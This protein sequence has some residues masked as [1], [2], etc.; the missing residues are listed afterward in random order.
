MEYTKDSIN[1]ITSPQPGLFLVSR[2]SQ[3]DKKRPCEEAFQAYTVFVDMRN[4][5][6]PKK[7]PAYNGTNGDWYER[8]SNHRIEDGRITRDL[9]RYQA[10]FVRI[11]D[12]MK[13]V[14]KYGTCVIDCDSNGIGTIEIYDDY[15]E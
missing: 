12:I 3:H 2:T 15:R 10:W 8:G 11:D 9:H 13:F 1:L 5:D 6:D 7:I 14:E 4:A